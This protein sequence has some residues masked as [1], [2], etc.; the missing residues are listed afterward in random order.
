MAATERTNERPSSEPAPAPVI[1]TPP[2]AGPIA[3]SSFRPRP[4]SPVSA[5]VG[6]MPGASAARIATGPSAGS[7]ALSYAPST[8]L[9]SVPPW[10]EKP[11]TRSEGTSASRALGSALVTAR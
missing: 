8:A 9:V 2:G 11:N 5:S 1:S 6:A 7:S 3:K 4:S 10:L